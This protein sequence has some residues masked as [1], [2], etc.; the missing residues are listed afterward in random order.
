VEFSASTLLLEDKKAGILGERS[1][2]VCSDIRDGT[3]NSN[4]A[5]LINTFLNLAKEEVSKTALSGLA[6]EGCTSEALCAKESDIKLWAVKLPWTTTLELMVD[7]TETFYV[8]L[9][10]SS[11]SGNPGWYIECLILGVTVQDEC[12]GVEAVTKMTAE[13]PNMDALFEEAFAELAEV[14]LGTCTKGGAE[15]AT[16]EGLGTISLVGGG[17]LT[18]SSE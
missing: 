5:G 14:K 17:T 8:E 15:T 4:G 10:A 12:T 16:V 2:I 11:G 13:A 9:I 1:D 18:A 3:I 7:G 6:L